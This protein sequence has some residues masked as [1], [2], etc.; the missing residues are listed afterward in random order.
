MKVKVPVESVRKTFP[1]PPTVLVTPSRV[2]TTEVSFRRKNP[3]P[4]TDSVEPTTGNPCGKP[5][6]SG[7]NVG[8]VMA[9]TS[10][11]LPT[12]NSTEAGALPAASETPT[13]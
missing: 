11:F 9:V 8:L 2:K 3:V 10:S 5:G 12:L 6:K 4:L 1:T 13:W 7:A